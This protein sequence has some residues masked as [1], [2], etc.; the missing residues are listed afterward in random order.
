MTV[1]MQ[2]PVL[3]RVVPHLAICVWTR[4]TRQTLCI[5]SGAD[6]QEAHILS[7]VGACNA[8]E[9]HWVVGLP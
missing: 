3:A 9:V 4:F 6:H 2:L 7:D 5:L 1:K 8:L